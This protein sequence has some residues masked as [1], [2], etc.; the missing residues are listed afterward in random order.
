MYI[1]ICRRRPSGALLVCADRILDETLTARPSFNVGG[2]VA[3][4]VSFEVRRRVSATL[5]FSRADSLR[6]GV[7]LAGLRGRLSRWLRTL[8]AR[9]GL[10]RLLVLALCHGASL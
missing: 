9:A 6:R 4:L 5:A 10:T 3:R 7:P 2:G 1:R 8:L